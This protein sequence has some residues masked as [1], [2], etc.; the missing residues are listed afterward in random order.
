MENLKGKSISGITFT[1]KS[2]ETGN[3][4]IWSGIYE[5][6]HNKVSIKVIPKNVKN[7]NLLAAKVNQ[8]ISILKRASYPLISTYI[9]SF[10]DKTN[11]YICQENLPTRTLSQHIK[12]NIHLSEIDARHF[13][14]E[15]F[16]IIE[17]LHNKLKVIIR[18]ISPDNILLDANNNIRFFDFSESDLYEDENEIFQEI[19]GKTEY[20]PPEMLK[21]QGYNKESDYWNLGIILYEM[22]TGHLPFNGKDQNQTAEEIKYSNL[23][24]PSDMTLSNE[25]VDL[26]NQMLKKNPLARIS[27]EGIKHH[28]WFSLTEYFVIIKLGKE[29]SNLAKYVLATF[30]DDGYLE[31]PLNEQIERGVFGFERKVYQSLKASLKEKYINDI[32][33]GTFASQPTRRKRASLVLSRTSNLTKTADEFHIQR[34]NPFAEAQYSTL[35]PNSARSTK[36]NDAQAQHS[37][38]LK[39]SASRSSLKPTTPVQIAARRTSVV[40]HFNRHSMI[41]ESPIFT[42]WQHA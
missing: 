15:L 25:I 16:V 41:K 18:N 17:Y 13:F 36:F 14:C 32:F 26:L 1:E 33:A 31:Q 38:P 34:E 6:T 4:V 27:T 28:P 22:V 9:T 12:E 8:E 5:E 7:P 42:N 10:E 19:C 23:Q 3:A 37:P 24:F 39:K 35:R 29:K 20:S 40:P 21:E 11:Y 2:F 30:L